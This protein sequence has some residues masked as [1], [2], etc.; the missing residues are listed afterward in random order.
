MV[1]S[2][3]A[4]FSAE[5]LISTPLQRRCSEPDRRLSGP[6]SDSEK[7][8]FLSSKENFRK[9]KEKKKKEKK[10]KKPKPFL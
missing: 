6:S 9:G 10:E 8:A 5:G 4:V 1:L 2:P 7:F 3:C